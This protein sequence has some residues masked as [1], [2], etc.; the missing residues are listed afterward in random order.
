MSERLFTVSLYLYSYGIVVLLQVCIL[1]G[2]V[3]LTCQVWMASYSRGSH[4]DVM[5]A[6]T[7]IPL[8]RYVMPEIATHLKCV[9]RDMWA[10]HT[11]FYQPYTFN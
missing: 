1:E 2:D 4:L 3:E 11:L 5:L 8:D 9:R 10:T 6:Y 7:H